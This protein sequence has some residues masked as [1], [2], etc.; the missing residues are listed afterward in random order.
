MERDGC[1]C[2]RIEPHVRS[3][4][5]RSLAATHAR[6]R[7]SWHFTEPQRRPVK[8]ISRTYRTQSAHCALETAGDG[9][10]EMHRASFSLCACHRKQ[11][12][13]LSTGCQHRFSKLAT[14]ISRLKLFNTTSP[15]ALELCLNLL[16]MLG[17]VQPENGSKLQPLLGGLSTSS[18]ALRRTCHGLT[19]LA[20]L[21]SLKLRLQL[22]QFFP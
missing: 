15:E 10:P 13:T 20:N 18:T 12:P 17:K 2:L 14:A 5:K 16:H 6:H 7:G 19:Y 22:L 4:K 9:V 1:R 8:Q 3:S 11:G 21:L